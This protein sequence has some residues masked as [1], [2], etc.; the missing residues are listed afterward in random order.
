MSDSAGTVLIANRGEVAVRIARAAHAGGFRVVALYTAD[1]ADALHVREADASVCLAGTGAAAYLDIEQITRAATLSEAGFV[2]PGWGFLSESA[3]FARS[4]ERAG[5]VFVGPTPQTLD[6]FGDKSVARELAIACGVPVLEATTGPTDLDSA[7]RFMTAS[8]GAVIVKAV[9]GGGGK[10]VRMVEHVDLLATALER[11]ASEALRSFGRADVYVENYLPRSRHIEVQIVGDGTGAVVHLW[12]RD[13]SLQRHHQKVVEIAP[14][15]ALDPT[16]E[17]R[18]LDAALRIAGSVRYR[19]VGTIEFLLD[20]DNPTEFYFI[21]GNP[22][23][24]VEHGV[25]EQVTGVDIVRLQLD[26]CRGAT[27]ASLGISQA[28]IGAATGICIEARLTLDTAEPVTISRF[29][30]PT[31]EGIRT[32]TGAFV[33]LTA[34]T[35]FDPLLAKVLVHRPGTDLTDA[36]DALVGALMRF[37]IA[38]PTTNLAALLDLLAQPDVRRGAL[39]TTLADDL[40]RTATTATPADGGHI[41][42]PIAGSVISVTV[43]SGDVVSRGQVLVVVEA[44]KMEHEVIAAV[45]GTIGAVEIS[46]GDQ[47]AVGQALA[48][49]HAA[50]RN[51]VCLGPGPRPPSGV[52]H[53]RETGPVASVREDTEQNLRRHD[54]V[55]DEARPD[56]IAKRHARGK[57][58]A[59]E[60]VADLCDNGSFVEY[61][62]LVIAA[63]RRRR[64]VDDLERNT[65]ADGLVAGFGTLDAHGRGAAAAQI[66]V[67]A[68]DYT[69]LAGTQGLQNHKKA[70]R[71]FELARRRSTPVVVFAEGGGG[72]PGDTDNSAKAT[73]M[74]LGTYVALGRLNARVPTVAIASGRCFAGNAAI[75]GSCDLA[76]ATE[77][78]NI[79]MGGPAMIAGGG[80]GTFDADD[81]GPAP[82]LADTGAIDVLVANEAAAVSVAKK[83]L[84]FFAGTAPEW[85]ATDQ[86][87]LRH[88]VPQKRTRTFDIRRVIEVLADT[89]SVLELRERFGRG[90]ITSLARIEGLPV[91]LVANNGQ[92]LGGAIDSDGADKLARFLHLCDTYGIAVVS[93]CDTP[94]FMVGPAS[95]ET[96]A[97]RHFGR[98]FVTG[99]NLS[100]PLCT[101]V[102]RKAYGLGGQAMAGGSFRVPEAIVAWP[103]G[104]FGAMGPE[105]A[106][107]LGFTRELDAIVDPI[108][109]QTE[110]DRLVAEYER[111]GRAYN[112]ASVFELDDVI[113][114]ADTRRVILATVNQPKRAKRPRRH[115]D[116][117]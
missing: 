99:P 61:G 25:T 9:S 21:E 16:T 38:G 65:P 113:D 86:Q 29:V 98:I 67:L 49:L 54:L 100:V 62:A 73:G 111:D 7:T 33:G 27:L 109:R 76:I 103:T 35:D 17:Q 44:M 1:E 14:A 3:A 87:E 57:R 13:C 39:T 55:L 70:E 45:S 4:C 77:D 80:L 114:P 48:T 94:G 15:P 6:T 105:G 8:R 26:L 68:Y 47:V 37:D 64:S 24:Q 59:R 22:R 88:L 11:A 116:A 18:M 78:A 92:Q 89:G 63:Q 12:T 52:E 84:A 19:G 50:N 28:S 30:P 41:C 72:R 85:S 91:G 23:L 32:D 101:V 110:F 53:A 95:E 51:P 102:I 90:M 75:V 83:Y 74:D 82:M 42:S 93:L 107:R 66:A 36:V 81:I 117:W 79:G 69:V 115:L 5:L 10:G 46:V 56:A 97:L 34:S 96:G 112:A 108:A 31:G 20:V 40:A 71:I 43:R 60:N 106:V 104:A 2:H 58:T